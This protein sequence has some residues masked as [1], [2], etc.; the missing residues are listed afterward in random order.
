MTELAERVLIREAEAAD[1]GLV[2]VLAGVTFYEAYFEQDSPPSLVDY[3]LESFE[4]MKIR[5][6]IE[7]A[8]STF[9]I[10][11]LDGHAV[12]YAKLR[13]ESK[14]D[15][16]SS[17]GAVE[18]Q[19]I[20]LVERVF[21][22]GIGEVLLRHCLEFAKQK[23]FSTLWLGVWE[24][25]TRARKFYAKYGFRRVGTITFPYGETVGINHVLEK[26]LS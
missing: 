9:F 14:V 17:E 8:Q 18:L 22:R 1:A 3:I 20:Y 10:I 24:E 13:E 5:A 2:S 7:S 4:L 25:N 23:G 11:Y 12:G 21:G 15:C 16:V 19:R 26:S 6:E